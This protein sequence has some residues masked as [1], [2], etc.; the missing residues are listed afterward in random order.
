MKLNVS[1]CCVMVLFLLLIF[2][3]EL[4]ADESNELGMVGKELSNQP[5][6]DYQLLFIGNSH[7]SANDLPGLVTRLLM[8]GLPNVSANAT[9]APGFGFLDGRLNDGVTQP[10]L[11]SRQWSH[12]ILQAQKYS[13]SGNYWYSTAAAEEWIRRVKSNGA[14]PILFPEWPRRGNREEGPRIHQLHLGIAAAEPACVAP[15]GLAWEE[16]IARHPTLNLHAPDGNHSNQNGALLTAFVFYQLLTDLPAKELPYVEQISASQET[17]R[18][19]RDV[20]TFVSDKNSERCTGVGITASHNRMD[21]EAGS[22]AN[23]SQTLTISSN[24]VLD[25]NI[26]SISEPRKPLY[27]SGSCLPLPMILAPSE[28]CTITVK[29]AKATKGS[30][31]GIL[32]IVSNAPTSPTSVVLNGF[33][34]PIIFPGHVGLVLQSTRWYR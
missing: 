19:L 5:L 20:A 21:F 24:G 2:S 22:V 30:Y 14:L 34:R 26:S 33:I 10:L 13:S 28:T 25:L 7:S 6:N 1:L 11:N 18:K 27:I 23:R 29:P 3:L 31:G 8:T 16:S 32:E 17:Q 4:A 12:V 9:L 15:V